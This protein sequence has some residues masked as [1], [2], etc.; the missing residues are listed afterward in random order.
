MRAKILSCL[1]KYMWLKRKVLEQ[2][3]PTA[4]DRE[5]MGDYW[6]KGDKKL[7]EKLLPTEKDA[8][9]CLKA[10]HRFITKEKAW[11]LGAKACPF[12]V[13]LHYNCY[14]PS[15]PVGDACDRC[16][17]GEEKGVCGLGFD[18]YLSIKQALRELG[19]LEDVEK[20]KTVELWKSSGCYDLA[21][22]LLKEV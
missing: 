2:Q 4:W 17:Y 9:E 5:L 6:R 12:C 16:P 10:L 13:H 14:D 19:K 8:R 20:V 1:N 7:L 3:A 11:L 18:A 21:E 22:K 15:N